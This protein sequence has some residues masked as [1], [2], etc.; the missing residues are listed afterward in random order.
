MAMRTF[1]VACDIAGAEVERVLSFGV[2]QVLGEPSRA[3]I[4][5]HLSEEVPLDDLV[6]KSAALAFGYE[7]EEPATFHGLVASVTVVA[8][9]AGEDDLLQYV[10]ELVSP[11]GLLDW[12]VGTE[13]FQG[14]DAKAIIASVLEARGLPSDVQE[15]R[16]SAAPAVR[17]TC[18]RYGERAID[19]V[20]RLCEEEGIW[21]TTSSE[22]GSE[23]PTIVFADDSTSAA[24]IGGP[25]ELPFR[26]RGGLDERADA[27]IAITKRAKT[28][29]GKIALRERDFRRPALDLS[30]EASDAVDAD[31]EAYEWPGRYE[32]AGAGKR[33][34]TIRLEA[35]LAARRTISIEADAPRIEA[36]RQLEIVE[37]E[38]QG[39]DGKWFVTA[40]HHRYARIAGTAVHDDGGGVYR[41][42]AD[43]VPAEVRYRP[44]CRTARPRIDGAQTARVVAPQGAPAE[45]IHTDKHGRAK[46]K[47][48]WDRAE[49]NDDRTSWWLRVGQVQTSGSL[50]LPRLG[51]E[52]VTQYL[53]GDPERAVVTGK[54]YNGA[55]MPPYA[56]PEGRARTSIQSRSTPGGGGTNEIRLDDSAGGEE[57]AISAQYDT[58]IKA[59]NN[60]TKTVHN[61]ETQTVG[62]NSSTK[63]GANQTVKITKGLQR[64]V[65]ADQKVTVGANRKVEVNAV[66]GLTVGGSSSITIGANHTE[67]DG[68]PLEGLITVAAQKAVEAAAGAAMK[69][70]MG[71]AG[72]AVAK[73]QQALG[74]VQ[75]VVA[76]AQAMGGAMQAVKN[77]N[78]AQAGVLMGAAA[79]LPGAGALA[80]GMSAGTASGGAPAA[81]GATADASAGPPAAGPPAA[82]GAPTSEGMTAGAEAAPAA[83]PPAGAMGAGM[84]VLNAA[85]NRAAGGAIRKGI[86]KGKKALSGESGGGDGGG[87]QSAANEAGPDGTVGAIANAD[88]EKGPGHNIHKVGAA[89]TETIGAMKIVAAA[90]TVSTNV[91]G[92]MTQNVAAARVEMVMGNHS[93]AAGATKTETEVG[94]VVVTKGDETESAAAMKTELVGGAILEKIGGSHT[95]EAGGMATFVGAFHKIDAKG[96]ITFKCGASSLVID[97]GGVTITSPL[98][99]IT[100][101]K[102]Q[103]TKATTEL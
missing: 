29:I 34:A 13:I 99:T 43:L 94:L 8:S 26:S 56:L 77:G 31:L 33:K 10:V 93:E 42:Q 28:T 51:W 68:N 97:G 7:G 21:F 88:R 20:R 98:V 60:K 78:L 66:S 65:G 36:G 101:A 22:P 5:L 83:G 103:L 55:L 11:L 85:I 27:V 84:N 95:I 16:L 72:A 41:A 2:D 32:D 50:L 48:P 30:V 14:K 100:A 12:E 91:A 52:V 40:V 9:P 73:V 96:K 54:L 75:R 80:G 49:A 46:V 18:V 89:L 45:E 82:S 81:G 63:V 1:E 58:T 35:E 74:P 37:S 70:A 90:N 39:V 47:F 102:I 67:M 17:E 3:E 62:V 6:G 76:Q 24:A 19:F 44:P 64:T 38:R 86:A 69:A 92:A 15:W 87:G 79:G 71:V 25:A 57:I 4:V 23:R 61:C 53:E 59:A